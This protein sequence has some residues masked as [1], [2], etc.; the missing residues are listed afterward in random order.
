MHFI[1]SRHQLLGKG[2]DQAVLA[3]VRAKETFTQAHYQSFKDS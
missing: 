2:I 1:L 3:I